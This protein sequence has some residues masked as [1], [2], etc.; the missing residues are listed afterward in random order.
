M[1]RFKL[2]A[3]LIL[4]ILALTLDAVVCP[5]RHLAI[6]ARGTS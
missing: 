2:L 6:M 4:G 5:F 3:L 1:R